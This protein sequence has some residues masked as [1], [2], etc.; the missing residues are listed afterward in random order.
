ILPDHLLVRRHLDDGRRAGVQK[1]VAVWQR[2]DV[3][4]GERAR[5]LPLDLALRADDGDMAPVLRDDAMGDWLVGAARRSGEG[6]TADE[7]GNDGETD[8][9]NAAHGSVPFLGGW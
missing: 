7:R 5:H 4:R 1:E 9:R 3:V 8:P 2:R 6:C